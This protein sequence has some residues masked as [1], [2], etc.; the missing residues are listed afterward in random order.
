MEILM[1]LYLKIDQPEGKKFMFVENGKIRKL[2]DGTR[3]FVILYPNKATPVADV[4]GKHLLRQDPHLVTSE[5]PDFTKP[6]PTTD[7]EWKEKLS[8]VEKANKE[9]SKDVDALT[10]E[11]ES[12]MD[13]IHKLEGEVETQKANALKA[14]NDLAEVKKAG[15]QSAGAKSK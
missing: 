15:G 7:E 6:F 11:A 8:E 2:R 4:D 14:R 13:Q 5:K 1:D 10:K 9:Y 12:L 3:P